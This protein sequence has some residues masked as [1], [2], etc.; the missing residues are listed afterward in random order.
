MSRRRP[1]IADGQVLRRSQLA[2]AAKAGGKIII[3]FDPATARNGRII[4][5][6]GQPKSQRRGGGR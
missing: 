5:R 3:G 1:Y 4:K 2:A 6:P